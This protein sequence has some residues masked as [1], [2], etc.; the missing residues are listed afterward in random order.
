MCAADVARDDAEPD[1]PEPQSARAKRRKTGPAAAPK[2]ISERQAAAEAAAA[3]AEAAK[4]AKC[5]RLAELAQAAKAQAVEAAERAARLEAAAEAETVAIE[6]A[7]KEYKVLQECMHIIRKVFCRK[8]G[9]EPRRI[10]EFS[11]EY[12]EA[13]R[14]RKEI[15][16][17]FPGLVAELNS[18][19]D[20]QASSKRKRVGSSSKEA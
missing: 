17:A 11:A 9:R 8:Y 15:L 1:H 16:A 6:V 10:D 14:R 7:K 20:S 19:K 12:Q 2:P 3:A 4:R 5:Y 13:Y 18:S